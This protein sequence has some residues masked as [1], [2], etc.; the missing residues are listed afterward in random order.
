MFFNCFFD[1]YVFYMV[2]L[3]ILGRIWGISEVIGR[4]EYKIN[5]VDLIYN[6]I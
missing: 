5:V 1:I 6:L 4:R 2:K 3:R